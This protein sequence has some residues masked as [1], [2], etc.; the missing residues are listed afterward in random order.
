MLEDKANAGQTLASTNDTLIHPKFLATEAIFPKSISRK[1]GA[2]H[3][4]NLAGLAGSDMVLYN[5]AGGLHSPFT[6][7]DT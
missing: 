3:N 1:Y 2:C 4:Q 7:W 5:Q 6:Q